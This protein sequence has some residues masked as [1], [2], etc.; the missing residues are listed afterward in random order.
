MGYRAPASID[1]RARVRGREGM[2]GNLRPRTLARLTRPRSLVD[3]WPEASCRR[4]RSAPYAG[5]CCAAVV[6]LAGTVDYAAEGRSDSLDKRSSLI[7]GAVPATPGSRVGIRSPTRQGP[8]AVQVVPG[9]PRLVPWPARGRLGPFGEPARRARP[10][11]AAP[12]ALSV[13]ARLGV[14]AQDLLRV[15]PQQPVDHV[16][17]FVVASVLMASR[18]QRRFLPVSAEV[19]RTSVRNVKQLWSQL[20]RTVCA[21][22]SKNLEKGTRPTP[23]AGRGKMSYPRSRKQT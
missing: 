9:R 20:Q 22:S 1:G 5:G 17:R 14:P 7:S 15:S 2:R 16:G 23:A 8:Q 3:A 10:A 21:T 6:A 12:S 4:R 19:P 11:T 13:T 18:N